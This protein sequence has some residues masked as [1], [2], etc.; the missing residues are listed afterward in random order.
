MNV[1][2]RRASIKTLFVRFVVTL[3][4]RQLIFSSF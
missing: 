4:R 1:D 3:D 2:E